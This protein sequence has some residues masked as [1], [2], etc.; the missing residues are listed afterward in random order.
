MLI[1]Y[2]I[3]GAIISHQENIRILGINMSADLKWDCHIKSGSTNM[4][5]SINAKNALIRSVK[6]LIPTKALGQIANNL[7]NSTILYG[8]P[9]WASTTQENLDLLQKSQM[10]AARLVQNKKRKNG[11]KNHRQ[12]ILTN[13]NWPNVKQI[14]MSATLNITHRATRLNTSSG[15]INMF[16]TITPR[17]P[18]GTPTYTLRHNGT[19][20]RS[21]SNFS[22]FASASL[23]SLPPLLRNPSLTSKKFKAEIKKYIMMNWM[24]TQHPNEVHNPKV[25]REHPKHRVREK[26]KKKKKKTTAEAT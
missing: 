10:R 14:T 1:Y 12:K 26:K 9:I 2:L 17:I 24:L 25:V 5:K 19:C 11:S 22:A 21:I 15:L 7:I 23:N 13:L 16:K 20:N 3:E 8:A 18:R 4:L 6:D